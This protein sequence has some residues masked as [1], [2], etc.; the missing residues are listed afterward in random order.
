MRLTPNLPAATRP[1][2]LAADL[3]LRPDSQ[4]EFWV[5]TCSRRLSVLRPTTPF[6]DCLVLAQ[7]MWLEVGRYDPEIAAELEHESGL[8]D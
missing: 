8:D 5:A 7:Q 3:S 2:S 6:A 1:E 4:S